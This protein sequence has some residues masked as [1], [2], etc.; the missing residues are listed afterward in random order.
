M[1]IPDQ[2]FLIAI[3]T[4]DRVSHELRISVWSVK[5]TKSEAMTEAEDGARRIGRGTVAVLE[6]VALMEAQG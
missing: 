1:P 6:M 5:K 4:E 3:A 2:R